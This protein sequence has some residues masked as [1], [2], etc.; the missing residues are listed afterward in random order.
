[1]P[2]IPS[3]IPFNKP[4]LSGKELTYI[5]DAVQR[6]KIS[7][8]GYYTQLCQGF[9]QDN[10][11]FE[12]CLL[13]NSCTDALE[14]AAILLDI[15]PGDEVICPS[16]TFVSS[17]NAFVLR[18]AR[19]VFVDSK[20]EHPS[21]D[22]SQLESLISPKTKAII[23]V[24]YGGVP[25]DMNA[26]MILAEKYG[27]K[28]IEDAAQAI[29]QKFQEKPL[30]GIGHIGVFSFHETKNIQCGEGGM[31]CINDSS[32]SERAEIIWEK[33]TDRA[34]FFRGEVGKYGWKDLGSS[35]LP[36]ELN[37]A[38]LYAQLESL[39]F[40]QNRRKAIWKEYYGFLQDSSF[41]CLLLSKEYLSSIKEGFEENLKN[42]SLDFLLP[43]PSLMA[44]AHL[45]FLMFEDLENRAHFADR[46]K[47][48]GI[49]TVFHYQSLHRSTFVQ[50]NFPDQ[51]HRHLPNSDRF[52]DRLIRLPLFYELPEMSNAFLG[53]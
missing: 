38:Y 37:A 35:F 1:M 24:H 8:N 25:C 21:M 3:Q 5:Q 50:R 51:Y 11:G 9:F 53:E 33:G 29:D 40:I 20:E 36:S 39:T 47:Q 4:Y 14:M 19:V 32:L 44:N 52:S 48:K 18:G 49:L 42:S 15:R 16:F 6:G 34:A 13:T 27:V 46:M 17:A 7:G 12:H 41:D 30:G 2:F 23:V 10:Y 43:D 22:E 28:V 31:I 26:I 45:F